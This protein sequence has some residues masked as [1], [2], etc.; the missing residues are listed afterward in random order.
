MN[1]KRTELKVGLFVIM[2]LSLLAILVMNFSKGFTFVR[3]SYQ[4]HLRTLNVGGIKPA[5]SVLMAGVPVGNVTATDLSPDGRSVVL[6]LKILN[7]YK[8]RKDAFFVIE[9]S[10][11]LGDQFVAIYPKGDSAPLLTDGEEVQCQEPFNLQEVA[12][13]AMGFIQRID[14][15]A[16]KLNEVI[17][18]VDRVVLN[19]QTLTNIALA[20]FQLREAS[21]RV[22]GTLSNVD[23]LLTTNAAPLHMTLTNF[24]VLS[25]KLNRFGDQVNTL[26]STNAPPIHDAIENLNKTSVRLRGLLDSVDAGNGV[27]GS[28]FKDEQLRTNLSMLITHLDV[29]SS[30]L[31]ITTSNL[32]KRGLW[33]IF[34]KPKETTPDTTR[35]TYSPRGKAT[36]R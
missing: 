12:R 36:T 11:F 24:V 15:T 28:L 23:N 26:V 29:T 31:T 18:R 25:D 30:N 21:E 2:C 10:G 19:E 8:V 34:R 27:V 33:G 6:T 22:Q 20:V 9:Q 17:A 3:Q 35:P 5:A 13:S 32:N 14:E 7:R 4:L 16:K 1:E